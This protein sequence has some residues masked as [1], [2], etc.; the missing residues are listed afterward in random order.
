MGGFAGKAIAVVGLFIMF[1]FV[2]NA[3]DDGAPE[4][5]EVYQEAYES[6][7][8]RIEDSRVPGELE[9]GVTAPSAQSDSDNEP[10]GA[11]GGTDESDTDGGWAD[12]S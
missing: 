1:I 11:W 12:E 3:F 9:T 8:Q 10:E 7:Q 6:T 4:R 2:Y 5:E